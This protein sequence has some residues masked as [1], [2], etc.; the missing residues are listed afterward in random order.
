MQR[1]NLRPLPQ[2][3]NP[4]GTRCITLTIPD[5]D[6]WENQLW[7]EAYRLGLW[8]LWERDLGHNGAIIARRWKK[9]LFT[10]KHCSPGKDT[11]IEESEYEMSVCEQLRFHNGKLQGFC[12]GVWTDITGQEMFD[13][14][15]PGQQGNGAPQ[16]GSGQTICYHIAQQAGYQYL[17]PTLVNTGDVLTFTN[18]GGAASDWGLGSIS[19]WWCPN[20]ERFLAGECQG[21]TEDLIGSDPMPTAPHMSLIVQIAGTWYSA[22]SPVTV[23]GGV[24]NAAIVVQLNDDV[25]GDDPGNYSADVCVKNNQVGTWSHTFIF[26]TGTHGWTAEASPLSGGWDGSKFIGHNGMTA[27]ENRIYIPATP[28]FGITAFS[29]KLNTDLALA[30]GLEFDSYTTTPPSGP[31]TT[32]YNQGLAN[33]SVANRNATVAGSLTLPVGAVCLELE[34]TGS[35]GGTYDE[36]LEVT[37]SGNGVDPF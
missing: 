22:L 31:A 13:L 15:H 18:L 30:G 8:Q 25:L 21:G 7:S 28:A 5:D 32:L 10:W 23:P 4:V 34:N 20:G 24:S 19:P 35:T 16:P 33:G 17:V 12:C 26:S 36:T 6:E 37:L 1:A 29:V 3:K 11:S 9:A 14:E 27:Y 2:N